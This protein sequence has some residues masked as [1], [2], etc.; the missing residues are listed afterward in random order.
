MQ[1]WLMT[2]GVAAGAVCALHIFLGGP[3]VAKPLLRAKDMNPVA[4][5]T[6]YYCWHTVTI[7]LASMALAFVLAALS[8][9][10]VELAWAATLLSA[11]FALWSI[12][13]VVWKKQKP[14]H[15]PQWLLFVAVT[16]LGGVG[17]AT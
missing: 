6:N 13:L 12:G 8:P 14:L 1:I 15:L 11:A 4:R 5:Y 10:A 16:A 2:A 7:V 3:A 17:L 9:P